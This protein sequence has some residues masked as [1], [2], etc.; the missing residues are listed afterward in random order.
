M[1]IGSWCRLGERRP[2]IRTNAQF[3]GI[4]GGAYYSGSY[5]WDQA[6]RDIENAERIIHEYDLAFWEVLG[7]WFDTHDLISEYADLLEKAAEKLLEDKVLGAEYW[8]EVL[9]STITPIKFR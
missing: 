8:E 7:I 6:G 3:W 1:L 4:I 5:N 9:I 2:K